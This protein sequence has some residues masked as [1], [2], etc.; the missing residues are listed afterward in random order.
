MFTLRKWVFC[1][2]VSFLSFSAYSQE[3][4]QWRYGIVRVNTNISAGIESCEEVAQLA[5]NANIDFIVF[6]DQFLV[7]AEYGVYP[8]RNSLKFSRKR[9]S[10]VS[11]G[12][13][14]YLKTIQAAGDKFSNMVLISGADIAPHYYW[15]GRPLSKDFATNQFSEQLTVF[16]PENPEFYHNLP[17]IHNEKKDISFMSIRDDL[18]GE[19]NIFFKRMMGTIQHDRGKA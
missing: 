6:S 3:S 16:G 5:K 11:Y 10:I 2:V 13:K 4:P 18:L 7:H 1:F 8:F 15:T 12:I 19:S 9:K 17:V 14:E